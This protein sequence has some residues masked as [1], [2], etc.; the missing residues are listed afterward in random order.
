LKNKD[1]IKKKPEISDFIFAYSK[2]NFKTFNERN[3]F[4][5]DVLSL[6]PSKKKY[7]I[8]NKISKVKN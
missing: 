4:F 7:F 6:T 8:K 1:N 3:K 5:D 2:T